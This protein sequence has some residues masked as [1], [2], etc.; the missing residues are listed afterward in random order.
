MW[1]RC[2][3]KQ[4][5]IS[6]RRAVRNNAMRCFHTREA[7]LWLFRNL[8]RNSSSELSGRTI[9]SSKSQASISRQN[10]W[11]IMA[12]F[13]TKK[14]W[15]RAIGVFK[16]FK[17]RWSGRQASQIWMWRLGKTSLRYMMI[18]MDS[19]ASRS[20]ILLSVNQWLSLTIAVTMTMRTNAVNKRL[21]CT[22][23]TSKNRSDKVPVLVN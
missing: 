12:R 17:R 13:P 23:I 15:L 20:S 8:R 22:L 7:C 6:W 3:V 1:R 19:T 4:Q 9:W 11:Q 2:V 18:K 14:H 21:S 5:T 10:C 16:E